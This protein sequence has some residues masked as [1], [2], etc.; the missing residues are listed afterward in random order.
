MYEKTIV[1]EN[2]YF[3]A[4]TRKL[5]MWRHKWKV[6]KQLNF[7]ES[8]IGVNLKKRNGNYEINISCSSLLI[9]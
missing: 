3:S 2:V 9:T 6:L 8:N 1:N 7:Y 5:C 4:K